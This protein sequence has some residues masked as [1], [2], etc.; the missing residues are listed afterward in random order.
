M[1]W[2]THELWFSCMKQD[3][4]LG[5][6]TN[7]MLIKLDKNNLFTQ[8]MYVE[9]S[10][11][12]DHELYNNIVD[13]LVMLEN[14]CT[15]SKHLVWDGKPVG[16]W[17]YLQKQNYKMRIMDYSH[18]RLLNKSILW[19]NYLREIYDDLFDEY[20]EMLINLEKRYIKLNSNTI[21]NGYDLGAWFESQKQKYINE[22][23]NYKQLNKLLKSTYFKRLVDEHVKHKTTFMTNISLIFKEEKSRKITLD[24]II[25]G[26][27]IGEWLEYNKNIHISNNLEPWKL[28][29]LS[30]SS[31]WNQWIND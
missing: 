19:R 13:I 8:F 21:L 18:M 5:T 27:H 30:K 11:W 26:I 14:K 22:D 7:D 10:I 3:Y 31:T 24:T 29:E 16:Y 15:I 17:F 12:I 23:M 2:F 28:C 4:Y 9:V 25:K 20:V 6:I 1:S